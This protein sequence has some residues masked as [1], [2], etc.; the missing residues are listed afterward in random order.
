VPSAVARSA[1]DVNSIL[2]RLSVN[3]LT[4]SSRVH[5]GLAVV[6]IAPR[7]ATART[8]TAN[9]G[10]FGLKIAHTSPL[11]SPRRASAAAARSTRP[12]SCAYEMVRPPAASIRAALSPR[13]AASAR[14]NAASGVAGISSVGRGPR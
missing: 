8:A 11:R 1:G 3:C 2:G 6:T 10:V 9:C 7:R 4:R 12:G 13:A 5:I 14:T